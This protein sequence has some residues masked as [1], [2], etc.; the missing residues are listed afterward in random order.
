MASV[1]LRAEQI[2]RLRKMGG[3]SA[4]IRYAVK[5]WKR[6]DFTISDKPEKRNKEPLQV[7]PLWKELDGIE[8]WQLREILDRHFEVLDEALHKQLTEE[9][10]R[11]DGVIA[12]EFAQLAAR[13][14]FIIENNV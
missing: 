7:F 8:D 9:I 5:R 2:E 14:P 4:I 6:G 1:R 12:A 13:G 3:A 10:K 11:L